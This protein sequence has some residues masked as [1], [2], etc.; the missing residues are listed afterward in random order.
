MYKKSRIE[1]RRVA[2]GRRALQTPCFTVAG[3]E[4]KKNKLYSLI[5]WFRCSR[6]RGGV[7]SAASHKKGDK[8]TNKPL[9]C[10]RQH[11][12]FS[13]ALVRICAVLLE[14]RRH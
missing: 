7:E 13:F 3:D 14:E 6:A 12:V 2:A 4:K 10:K 9:N 1:S 8:W 11:N 5:H